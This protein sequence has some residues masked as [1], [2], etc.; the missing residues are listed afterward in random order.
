MKSSQ[1]T[2]AQLIRT[3]LKSN[4]PGFKFSVTSDYNSIRIRWADGPAPK[5]IQEITNKYKTAAPGLQMEVY[6]R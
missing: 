4:F 3:K 2:A 5:K 6:C 1:P